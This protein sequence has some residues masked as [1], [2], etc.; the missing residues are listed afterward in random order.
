MSAPLP[1]IPVGFFGCGV[2]GSG[3]L[4]ALQQNQH[5]IQEQLGAR[6]EVRR[7]CVR[8][9]KRQRG[10]TL[11][12]G[13]LT[14]DPAAIL[15]DPEI[16][17]VVEVMGGLEPAG[18]YLG[19]ALRA[20]KHCVTANKE[21]LAKSGAELL[22]EAEARRLDLFFEGSVAGGIPILRALQVSLAGNQVTELFGIVNGTTNY[23]LTQMAQTGKSFET[24][25]AEAQ[26]QGYAEADPTDD[27]DGYDAVY[28]LAI[29]AGIAF[30]TRIPPERIARQGIREVAAQDIEYA[31]EL[32]YTIKLLAVARE[33][34][35]GLELRV[36]PALIPN[37]HP[38][39]SVSDAYNA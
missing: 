37:A 38:L 22:R 17:I 13:V 25:L 11:S 16:R 2:V 33:A 15:D 30:R 6:L 18:E 5:A 31:R 35:E 21:L 12:P 1:V 9:E 8:D 27:V 36:E 26:A 23:I 24:A 7:V 10:V 34:E 20:G 14:T 4:Q 39:A 3:T 29:L 32:G 28:K 19:K